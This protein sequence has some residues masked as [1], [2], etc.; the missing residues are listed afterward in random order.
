MALNFFQ[1]KNWYALHK[2][3]MMEKGTPAFKVVNEID[4][5]NSV[6]MISLSE[7]IKIKFKAQSELGKINPENIWG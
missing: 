3:E 4:E 1:D 5:F 7:T 6:Y 2:K